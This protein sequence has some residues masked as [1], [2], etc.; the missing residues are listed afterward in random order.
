MLARQHDSPQHNTITDYLLKVIKEQHCEMTGDTI[1]STILQK[2]EELG[3]NC[4][5][6]RGQGYDGSGSMVCIRKGAHP[7]NLGLHHILRDW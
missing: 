7:S 2:L 1:A 6:L 4:E 3:L 5:Y